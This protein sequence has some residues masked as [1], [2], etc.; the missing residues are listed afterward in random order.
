[1]ERPYKVN[2]KTIYRS[3]STSVSNIGSVFSLRR[4]VINFFLFPLKLQR[5]DRNE[6]WKMTLGIEI[7]AIPLWGVSHLFSFGTEKLG[8]S[9]RALYP[10]AI[11]TYFKGVLQSL[12]KSIQLRQKFIKKFV[13]IL[14]ASLPTSFAFVYSKIVRLCVSVSCC[15]WCLPILFFFLHLTLAAAFAGIW[16]AQQIA[17][18]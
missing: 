10:I 7:G 15:C 18:G 8:K 4:S 14:S 13:F 17:K 9:F 5:R 12:A 16:T 1:M 6:Q 2:S 3:N 11:I